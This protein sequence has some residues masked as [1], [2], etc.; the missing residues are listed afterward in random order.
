MFR[1]VLSVLVGI[2][3]LTVISFAVEA[4]V[5]PLLLRAFPEALPGPPGA[6]GEPLGQGPDVRL[7]VDVC[8]RWRIRRRSPGAPIAGSARGC[9]GRPPGRPHHA[10]YAVSGREP[11][12]PMGM[13]RNGHPDDPCRGSRRSCLQ[14]P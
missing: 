10:G 5:N 14:R 12:F 9:D 11:R 4:A 6:R 2:V 13:D 8:S 7:W 1:S 3:V